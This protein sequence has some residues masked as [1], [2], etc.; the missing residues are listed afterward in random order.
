MTDIK[1]LTIEQ[2]KEITSI[3]TASIYR[4]MANHEFPHSITI[5]GRR[6]AWLESEVKAWIKSK[7]LNAKLKVV[8]GK[9]LWEVEEELC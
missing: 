8:D 6:V 5:F 2:V 9:Q 1:L 3:S 7:A 4:L